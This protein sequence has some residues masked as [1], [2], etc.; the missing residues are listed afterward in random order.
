MK[1][2]CLQDDRDPDTVLQASD[3]GIKGAD[4]QVRAF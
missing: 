1:S 2:T 4:S 3:S